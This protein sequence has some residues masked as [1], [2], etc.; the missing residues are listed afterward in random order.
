MGQEGVRLDRLIPNGRQ[1]RTV[2]SRDL[3]KEHTRDRY[4]AKPVPGTSGYAA[5]SSSIRHFELDTEV[6]TYNGYKLVKTC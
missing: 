3:L 5:F 2:S 6:K 4:R 1:L